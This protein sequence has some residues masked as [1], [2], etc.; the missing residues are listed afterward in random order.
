M[1]QFVCPSCGN[2]NCNWPLKP[3]AAQPVAIVCD[4]TG[5][6][7]GGG[8][9]I[10]FAVLCDDNG[11]F[12]AIYS[13]ETEEFTYFTPNDD[14]TLTPYVPD[15]DIVNCSGGS[16]SAFL[17]KLY[18]DNGGF[19]RWYNTAAMGGYSDYAFDG[20]IYVPV[21]TIYGEPQSTP[22]TLTDDGTPSLITAA[23]AIPTDLRA[24]TIAVLAG[25]VTINGL[26][27]PTGFVLS[28]EANPGELLPAFSIDGTG[29]QIIFDS[30]REV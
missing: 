20:N 19:I 14:G 1:A 30:I 10:S 13:S 21:G 17:V 23:F 6:G 22:A 9:S 4:Y 8:A 3:G 12:V 16:S 2:V 25:P 27:V 24:F 26:T 28:R 29:G 11:S 15:G 7:G 5:G 18:D